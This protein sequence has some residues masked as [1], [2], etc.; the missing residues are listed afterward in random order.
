MLL[1][2]IRLSTRGGGGLSLRLHIASLLCLVNIVSRIFCKNIAL[3]EIV[4]LEVGSDDDRLRSWC[5]VFFSNF[6]FNLVCSNIFLG[7]S[8]KTRKLLI[9]N[10]FK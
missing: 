10:T 9:D 4:V 6:P 2:F 5:F 3:F 1:R 8:R 7:V